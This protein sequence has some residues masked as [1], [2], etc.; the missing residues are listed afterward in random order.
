MS[1]GAAGNAGSIKQDFDE[2]R[3]E[4]KHKKDND[5]NDKQR[6]GSRKQ[7]TQCNKLENLARLSIKYVRK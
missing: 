6:E 5:H 3:Y 4:N 1:R 7:D 2:V